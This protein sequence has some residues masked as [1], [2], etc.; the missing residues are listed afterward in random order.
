[1]TRILH[2]IT[3][4]IGGGAE[5]TVKN[6]IRGLQNQE[7]EIHL[8][9]GKEHDPKRVATIQDMGIKTVCFE[10]IE[11]YSLARSIPAVVQVARYLR[12]ENIE[13]IHTHSTEAGII[14][15]WAATIARTPVVL[16][17]IHGDPIA[18]DRHTALNTFILCMERLSAPLTTRIIVKSERI[19]RSFIDRGI[20]TKDKYKLIYHGIDL[21]RFKNEAP[22]PLPES[23]TELRLLF[24]GRLQDGKGLFDLIEACEQLGSY[25]VDLLIAG[26]GPLKSDLRREIESRGLEESIHLLGYREDVPEL[27]AASDVLVLP[28]YREG[29][30]RVVSEAL[31]SG[32]PVVSTRIAGIPEQVSHGESGLLIDPG[33]VGAL[34]DALSRLLNSGELRKEMSESCQSQVEQF[35]VEREQ[36]EI[37]QLY[38]RLCSNIKRQT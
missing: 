37:S 16:H 17:E 31:A 33:D 38:Q 19:Q 30:P 12:K 32:T 11:H 34:V 7:Y 18:E 8:G 29:T 9:F 14:G 26:D 24:I 3:R 21:N 35:S 22:A 4:F 10:K 25:D 36:R 20:G 23:D 15:R 2:L 6:Q 5:K 28:S 27:L 1:M 13:L